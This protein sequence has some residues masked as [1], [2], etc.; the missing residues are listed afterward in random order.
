[1]LFALLSNTNAALKTTAYNEK[2]ID[3]YLE[4]LLTSFF[5]FRRWQTSS[6]WNY[7]YVGKLMQNVSFVNH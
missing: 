1:M 4:T 6:Y 3:S 7:A 5:K 2:K